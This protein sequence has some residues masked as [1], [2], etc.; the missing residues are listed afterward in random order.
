MNKL[1]SEQSNQYPN[2]QKTKSTHMK[3][4][5]RFLASCALA[6]F[7]CIQAVNAQI[8]SDF[9]TVAFTVDT[10]NTTLPFTQSGSSFTGTDTNGILAGVFNTPFSLSSASPLSLNFL[11]TGTNQNTS[12]T[13]QLLAPTTFNEIATYSGST[14][15]ATSASVSTQLSLTTGATFSSQ[16]IGGVN[17]TFNGA[18]GQAVSYQFQNL[19]VVPEPS[20]YALM[21]I[22]G[23]MLLLVARRRKA[24]D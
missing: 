8:L 2:Q 7:I 21:A 19:E 4:T 6:T 5:F 15:G 18:G 16:T 11:F 24:Q 23:L 9:G 3:K 12:F 17:I 10:E 14:A 20:T 1:D 22:G 13:L